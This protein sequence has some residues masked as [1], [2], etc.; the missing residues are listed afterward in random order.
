MR[1]LAKQILAALW[2]VLLSLALDGCS[3]NANVSTGVG[4]YRSSSGNWGT[5]LSIGVHSHS[6][7]W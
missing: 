3:G 7:G 1:R 2:L 5:S 4:I 6:R